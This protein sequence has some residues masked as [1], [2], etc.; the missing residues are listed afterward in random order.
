MKRLLPDDRPREKLLQRG[1]AALG[2]NELLALV[3]GVGSRRADALA[4]ATELLAAHDGLQGLARADPNRLL[5]EFGL[6]AARAARVAAAL[7]LG[8]RT[9]AHPPGRRVP[10]RGPRDAAAYLLPR[11]G[12]SEIER[13]GMLMLDAR[14][15]VFRTS[16]LTVG[17][18]NASILEPRDVYREAARSGATAIVVF[19]T[20]PSGD[21]T[22]SADDVNLTR[23]LKA[24]GELIGIDMVDHLVLGDMTYVSFK[25]SRYL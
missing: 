11:F 13:C 16:V 12:S 17:T 4:M 18:N 24:A 6:G 3:V 23:R 14:H 2:D 20:H 19:H 25:E 1:A 21:P 8:R 10:I 15:R 7:E 22:P 5:R 9:F